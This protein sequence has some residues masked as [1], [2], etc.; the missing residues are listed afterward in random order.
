MSQTRKIIR[1]FIR[2]EN[3]GELVVTAQEA[4]EAAGVSR[5]RAHQIL[6][7]LE[8]NGDVCSVKKG[9]ARV[10]YCP[11]FNVKV[12]NGSVRKSGGGMVSKLKRLASSKT[13]KGEMDGP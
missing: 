9:Q 7:E 11:D 4:G 12:V 13:N 2:P 5:A 6:D 10:W 3:S 1:Q 8:E